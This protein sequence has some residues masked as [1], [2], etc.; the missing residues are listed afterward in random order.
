MIMRLGGRAVAKNPRTAGL[1]TK[2]YF[3]LRH[4]TTHRAINL[5]RS[6]KIPTEIAVEILKTFEIARVRVIIARNAN[7]EIC[8]NDG[9]KEKKKQ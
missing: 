7:N 5:D 3:T 6:R 9:E 1:V 8:G 4:R 2:L